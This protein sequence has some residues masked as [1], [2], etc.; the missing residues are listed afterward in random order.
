MTTPGRPAVSVVIPAFNRAHVITRALD[1]VY[2]QTF[3]DFEVVIVDDASGDG[4]RQA[5]QRYDWR[6]SLIR[7]DK[8]RGAAGARNAAIPH[9]RAEWIAFLDSDDEWLPEK[10]ERQL[11]ATRENADQRDVVYCACLRQRPGEKP[12]IRPKG[13]LS[14]GVILDALLLRQHAPTASAYI[15]RRTALV[16][17]KGFDETFPTAVDIDLWLRLATMGC[18]FAAV[19]DPLVIKHDAGR[20]QMKQDA[21]A[22][23][24]GF[25]R[26][27]ERWGPTM[28]E[29][30]GEDGYRRW[31]D[32]RARRIARKQEDAL[33]GFVAYD[34]RRE[35][36]RYAQ[37][38]AAI[39]PW[40]KRYVARALSIAI[41]GPTL[42][43]RIAAAISG[44][45][46]AAKD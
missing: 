44:P 28:C 21:A 7:L 5:V 39:L 22:K 9:T 40:S 1:S 10:L 26:M 8:R 27:D 35:A 34:A 32:K 46:V 23:A 43:A 36:V 14:D 11:D 4:L 2:A 41:A 30:L 12:A 38:M 31:H 17:A 24:I 18:R 16:R 29:R 15:V 20:D 13:E 37:R 6:V 25:R 33:A 42:Y 45:S 3:Q 19:Q